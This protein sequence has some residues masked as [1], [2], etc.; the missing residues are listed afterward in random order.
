MTDTPPAYSITAAQ[1]AAWLGLLARSEASELAE[2]ATPILADYRFEWL[3]RPQSGLVM[4]R[5]RIGNTGDRYN[6]GEVSITR[7][8][9]RHHGATGDWL[10]GVG[11]VLGL[12]AQRAERIAQLDALLQSS[13]LHALIRVNVIEPL[14]ARSEQRRREQHRRTETTRVQFFNL[15]PELA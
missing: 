3:R 14:R 11:Y 5:S 2:L 12:D 10:A 15:Q 8:A 4:A 13:A 6:L 9:V 1:R 7:C